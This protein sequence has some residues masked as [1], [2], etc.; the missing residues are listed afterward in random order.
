[1]SAKKSNALA[2]GIDMGG[3]SVKLGVCRGAE[4]LF[5]ADP[6]PTQQFKGAKDLLAAMIEG[7]LA[8]KNASPEIEAVGVG[9]PGFTDVNTGM[10]YHLTN[11]PGWTNVSLN[12]IMGSATGI[13][14]FAENDANCMAYAEFKHGAGQGAVNM[15]GVTLGTGVGG[16]LVLNGE[17]FRGSACGAGE[18]G[19][20]SIDY[21]GKPGAYGNTGAIEEYV[22]NREMAAR[23]FELYKAAGQ[24]KR[25]EDCA[26]AKLS[27]A[28]KQGDAVAEQVWDEFTSQLA[29]SLANCCWLI[30]PD[31]IVIGGGIAKAGK[32]LFDPLKKKMQQQLH[33]TF[34]SGLRIIPAHFGN[35]AGII[36]SAAVALERI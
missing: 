17:L 24:L 19:Q 36:G 22:G 27:E 11:V 28:A 25:L 18:I 21:Q 7:V 12:E 33:K 29:C 15:L 14:T 4:L 20:M 5:H 35:E 3:T 8:L 32:L 26:P 31:T 30:N 13:P 2:I 10:V 9:V 23:A 1:M 16:G 6:I 34:K